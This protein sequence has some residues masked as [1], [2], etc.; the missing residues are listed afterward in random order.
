MSYLNMI[1][2]AGT[3]ETKLKVLLTGESDSGK[4]SSV[5]F[6]APKPLLVIDLERGTDQ[7]SKISPFKIFPSKAPRDIVGLAQE[8]SDAKRAGHELPYKSVFIDSG[9]VLYKSIMQD[10]IQ[11]FRDA[12]SP[13]KQTLEP[14]EYEIPK[15]IFYGIIRNLIDA[16]LHLFVSAHAADNY[17]KGTFMKVDPNEPIKPDCEKRLTHEMDVHLMFR[18]VGQKR[19]VQIKK[20]RLVDKHGKSLLPAEIKNFDNF[21]LVGQLLEM[22]NKDRGFEQE[23]VQQEILTEK[24]AGIDESRQRIIDLVKGLGIGDQ[25]AFALLKE[26]TGNNNLYELDGKQLDK[27][28]VHLEQKVQEAEGV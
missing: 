2:D 22:A 26:L 6:G 11:S 5:I 4:S 3:G 14:N 13:N 28:I 12:G 21:T 1:T 18:K 27:V 20:S 24:Q 9:T 17:M 15:N 25:A 19:H 8:L 23:K 7:Y 16:D 10:V